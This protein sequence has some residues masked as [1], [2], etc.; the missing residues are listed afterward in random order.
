[1]STIRAFATRRPGATYLALTFA[2]SW[3]GALLAIGGSGGMRGTTPTSDPRFVYALMAMLAGPTAA[4]IL[5]TAVVH[6]RT[7]CHEFLSRLITWRVGAMWY[8][9]VLLTAP[10]VMSA[11]TDASDEFALASPAEATVRAD[12]PSKKGSGGDTPTGA[13]P[14]RKRSA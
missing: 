5:L 2:I 3:G 11:A 14:R 12:R 8:A 9:V 6:G 7:G 13:S 4:G 1:M 10:V